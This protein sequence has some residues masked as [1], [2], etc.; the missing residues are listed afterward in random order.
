[1]SFK[2][3]GVP[4]C[5]TGLFLSSKFSCRSQY[6][7]IERNPNHDFQKSRL[8]VFG[9]VLPTDKESYDKDMELLTQ[10]GWLTLAET[11]AYTFLGIDRETHNVSFSKVFLEAK[12]DENND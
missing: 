8:G 1:M 11:K 6:E 4:T 10:M 2:M 3:E 7:G 12:K 5:C 9:M